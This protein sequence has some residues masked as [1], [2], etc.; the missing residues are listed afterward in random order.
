M[1]KD[2]S[3]PF[4][5]VKIDDFCSKCRKPTKEEMEEAKEIKRKI[6]EHDAKMKKLQLELHNQMKQRPECKHIVKLDEGGWMYNIR[7]CYSCGQGLGVI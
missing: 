6:E 2:L 7:F 1:S 4:V 5:V 3:D